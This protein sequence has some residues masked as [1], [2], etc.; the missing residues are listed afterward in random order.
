ML[1]EQE[2]GAAPFND[3]LKKYIQKF[4]QKSVIT[5]DWQDFLYESFPG[6]K[7]VL[8]SIDWNNWLHAAGVPKTK[9]KYS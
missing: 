7:D 9:P 1:I 3:F 6:K 2:L 8:D 4:A 5:K